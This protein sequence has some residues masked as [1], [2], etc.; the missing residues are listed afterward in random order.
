MMQGLQIRIPQRLALLRAITVLSFLLC[1][2]VTFPLWYTV[3]LFPA[4]S[5]FE[6]DQRSSELPLYLTLVI[7]LCFSAS[8]IF[9]WHRLLLILGLLALSALLLLDLNRLQQ[10]VF[11]YG[12]MLL[13]LASYNGRVDEPSRF[14]SYFIMLQIIVCSLY[15]FT[16][17]YQL[18][19]GFIENGLAPALAPVRGLFSP[20]QFGF[21]L[22]AGKILPFVTMF[23]AIALFVAPLRYLGITFAIL[24]HL[25]LILLGYPLRTGDVA[26]YIMNISMIPLV[27]VLF[28]G[29]TKE[30][31][32]SPV[33]LL[34]RPLFYLVCAVFLVMPFFNVTSKW[35]DELSAN[36]Y[37]GNKEKI[38]IKLPV[39][40]YLRLPLFV[41]NFCKPHQQKILLDHQAWCRY[42]LSVSCTN[43]KP[44]MKAIIT[45][46]EFW[47]RGPVKDL[48]LHT[49]I[50]KPLLVKP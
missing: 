45:Q 42:E 32:F 46:L 24:L 34:Q 28:S 27:L 37:S 3:H 39:S 33:F 35:P 43:S 48:E 36:V 17:F 1:I 7:L 13:V 15:F 2:S 6:I 9:R 40:T 50:K 21:I 4:A 26:G 23:T 38:T 14:T 16:G 31:Y 29:K 30:R 19:D 10:W 20:R 44:V 11:I 8:F 5:V 12:S 25:A 22:T 49:S 41:K 18:Q 47:N